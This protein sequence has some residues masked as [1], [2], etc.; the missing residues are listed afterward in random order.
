[1]S[2][3]FFFIQIYFVATEELLN[4]TSHQYKTV[5]P[6]KRTHVQASLTLKMECAGRVMAHVRLWGMGLTTP[7]AL[8]TF[9]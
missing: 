2:E 6:G 4:S 5:A 8:A 1:M 9:I 7:N 3:V